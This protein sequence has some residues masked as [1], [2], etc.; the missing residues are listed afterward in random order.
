VNFPFVHAII[1]L[2]SYRVS[3][4]QWHESNVSLTRLTTFH[5]RG[6]ALSA[7]NFLCGLLYYYRSNCT[8]WL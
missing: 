8:T 3:V 2:P 6:L 5:E 7:H 1:F 4:A